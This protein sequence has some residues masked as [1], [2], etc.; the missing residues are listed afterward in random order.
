[1]PDWRDEPELDMQVIA[2]LVNAVG[3]AVFDGMK[4][5]FVSDLTG[6]A[7]ACEDALGKGDMVA[8]KAAAHALKGAASN[9]GLV[10]LSALAAQVE[11][12]NTE[13]SH[14]LE[15]ELETAIRSL[16]AA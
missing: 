6:L 5:Q 16:N 3:Q 12:G 9:I 10:R 14:A 11:Q 15:T 13:S 7:N 2:T 8:A 4:V 1:M